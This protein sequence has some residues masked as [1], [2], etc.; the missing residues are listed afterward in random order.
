MLVV[1]SHALVRAGVSAIVADQP[2]L[3]VVGDVADVDAAVRAAEQIR[4]DVV[5]LASP[6]EA[7]AV[8]TLRRALPRGCILCLDERGELASAGALCVRADADLEDVCAMLGTVLEGGCAGCA[9][10][11]R[12]P[13]PGLA[14]AL[15][16]REKQVAVHVS[17]GK[18]SKQIAAALGIRL[19][20]VN[21]YRE[22]LARKIGASSAAVVTRYVLEHGLSFE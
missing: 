4:P 2:G 16:R 1:A 5:L 6:A 18:S 21:T 11:D 20:T 7:T 19:R 17:Q 12:C 15:S 8:A 10:R 22:S 9:V 3:R 14:V 13:A